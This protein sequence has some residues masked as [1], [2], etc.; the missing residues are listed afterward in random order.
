MKEEKLVAGNGIEMTD[1]SPYKL[2]TST[3]KDHTDI[4][5]ILSLMELSQTKEQ[6]KSH[7][8]TQE[9]FKLATK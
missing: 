3:I 9:Y 1:Y 7:P 8:N 5:K 6:Y 4:V 2:D